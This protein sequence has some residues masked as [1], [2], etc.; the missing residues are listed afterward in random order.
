[1]SEHA[2]E[3][4][5]LALRVGE[6]TRELTAI[7]KRQAELSPFPH[8]DYR[9]AIRPDDRDDD[10]MNYSTLMDDIVVRDVAMFRAEQMDT[11][12]WWVACYLNDDSGDR[13]CWNVSAKARP[14]R[15]DWTTSEYPQEP[16]VYEHELK[17]AVRR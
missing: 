8:Q 2:D 10:P 7:R 11:H 16:L 6:L 9:I 4:V 15:I 17:A 14:R 5:K 3:S 12:S 1:M 13:I